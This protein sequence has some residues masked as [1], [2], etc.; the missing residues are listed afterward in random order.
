MLNTYYK[1]N[2]DVD[3][4]AFVPMFPRKEALRGYNQAE[5]LAKYISKKLD[6]PLIYDLIKTKNTLEQSH[7]NKAERRENLKDSFKLKHKKPINTLRILLV[8]DIITTGRTMNE[9]SRVLKEAG[10]MEVIGLA[11]TSS[12]IN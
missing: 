6:K 1:M 2:I 9:C 7:L 11:I 12:K 8:D 10:A 3:K 5:L 4:I